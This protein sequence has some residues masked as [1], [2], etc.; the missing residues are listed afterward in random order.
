ML[1]DRDGE[2]LGKGRKRRK[3]RRVAA[4]I[5]GDD[6]R[7]LGTRQHRGGGRDRRGIGRRWCGGAQPSRRSR[8]GRG[9]RRDH[10]AGKA[11]IDR[12]ARLGAGDRQRPVDHGLELLAVAQLVVPFDQLAEH[13]G[14]VVHLLGPVDVAVA[15]ARQPDLRQRRSARGE[16]DR[17]VLPRR[18]HRR[19][20]H[21]GGADA[22]M[23]HDGG[24]SSRHHGVAMR[25]RHR[26]VLVGGE[27][28]ARNRR[29]VLHGVRIGL[30][31]RRK[32]GAGIAEQIV[33]LA[34]GEQRQIGGGDACG[35]GRHGSSLEIQPGACGNA[36]A[37]PWSIV[38]ST[39]ASIGRRIASW[40]A[41]RIMTRPDGASA[42]A[43]CRSTWAPP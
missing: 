18:V 32:V 37:S 11:Q 36:T 6:E 7:P 5:G 33:D 23:D 30:D 20:D 24:N 19:A 42:T 34:V 10:L 41:S 9:R 31:D 2:L 15:R 26:E 16:Q 21:V 25:H 29:A 27:D 17:D 13:A 28:R 35:F 43:T 39:R 4:R 40:R 38:I 1:G 3:G 22:D 8:P 12:A 14:L